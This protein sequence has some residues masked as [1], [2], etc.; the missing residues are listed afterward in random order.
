MKARAVIGANFGDEAK[1]AV[2]DWLCSQGAGTVVRFSGGA[3]AGHTV[4]TPDGDRHVFGHFGSGSFLG[5]P[6]FLSQYF[7]V[8]P[9]LFFKEQADLLK[10]G[11]DPVVFAHPD[12]LVTTF[13][14]M[15]IN[16]R[17]EDARGDQRHGSVGVGVNET[18]NRS[19]IPEL[20]ITIGDIW[21]HHGGSLENKLEQMCG[22]YAKFRTGS[23]IDEPKMT[24]MFLKACW[25]FAEKIHPAGI[26]QCKDPVFEGSQGLLL[27]QNRKEFFPHLTRSNTGIKNVLALCKQAGI[28]EIEPYYVSRTYLTRH[29]AGPLPG[30]NPIM[31]FPDDTNV[32][33]PYQG[34]IR[35]APL[36]Y[37][38][39]L[40][41]CREDR[42][43]SDYKLVMTHC[44][45]LDPPGKADF[46][47]FGPTRQDFK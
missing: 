4:V 27:D 1:G 44:D 10:L 19:A 40:T 3:N 35:F 26:G 29:G 18:I 34:T 15:M 23:V 24:E 13:A 22:Q 6:T 11:Y 46:Y 28:D 36:E 31:S 5:I 7:V 37:Y 2:V 33:H 42:G 30:H 45:Q 12:C 16:Q 21:N 47:S 41:R 9:I 14:D 39:L 8:N 43:S 17:L 25:A 32:N 20:K 38:G